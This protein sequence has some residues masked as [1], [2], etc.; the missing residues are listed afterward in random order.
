MAHIGRF[1]P[2]HFRRDLNLDLTNNNRG[3]AKYYVA[4]CNGLAG[5]IGAYLVNNL[6]RCLA[7][8]ELTFKLAKW[9]SANIVHG[10][11]TFHYELTVTTA[12]GFPD[13]AI[14]I[15]V[16]DHAFGMVLRKD[17]PRFPRQQFT[18][19]DA[20]LFGATAPNPTL[21]QVSSS[22]AGCQLRALLWPAANNP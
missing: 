13:N 17:V 15:E 2:V 14:R 10:G 9:K 19:I 12:M 4:G 20:S 6:V 21:L 3:Y 22:N 8:E 1:Y 5:I 11:R 7:V 18:L 16:I